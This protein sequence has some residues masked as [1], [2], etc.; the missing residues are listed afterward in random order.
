[1][2]LKDLLYSVKKCHRHCS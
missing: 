2:A 1:M